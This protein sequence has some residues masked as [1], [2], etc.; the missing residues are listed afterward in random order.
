MLNA[1]LVRL[2]PSP[3]ET[4]FPLQSLLLTSLPKTSFLAAI[5]KVYKQ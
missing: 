1:I 3:T 4:K 2:K 5:Q